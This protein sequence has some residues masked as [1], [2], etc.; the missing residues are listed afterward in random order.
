[1]KRGKTEAE[2]ISLNGWKVG[3]VLEGK[4]GRRTD[5][6]M[7]TAVGLE[8]ILAFWENHQKELSTTLAHREWRKVSP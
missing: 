2:T 3:D 4:E 8:C 7:I 5:R 1:M 6:I